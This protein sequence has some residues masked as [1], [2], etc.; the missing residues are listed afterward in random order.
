MTQKDQTSGEHK[1]DKPTSDGVAQQPGIKSESSGT[2]G[3]QGRNENEPPSGSGAMD[4]RGTFGSGENGPGMKQSSHTSKETLREK[5]EN[6]NH[7]R[8]KKFPD[9]PADPEGAQKG[10]I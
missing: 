3:T 1:K 4:G 6:K 5:A 7:G 8:D 9:G 2:S 10:L